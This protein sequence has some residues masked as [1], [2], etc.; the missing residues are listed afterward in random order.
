M[1]T[2]HVKI[3][4]YCKPNISVSVEYRNVI[5]K[6]RNQLLVMKEENGSMS[7]QGLKVQISKSNHICIVGCF[8]TID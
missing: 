8:I 1:Y 6:L 7:P 2:H 5:G 3:D 4:N